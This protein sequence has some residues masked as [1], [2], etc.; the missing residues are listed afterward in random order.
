[1]MQDEVS[2]SGSLALSLSYF[3]AILQHNYQ[4]VSRGKTELEPSPNP[5]VNFRFSFLCVC[6]C[7]L[8]QCGA[9]LHL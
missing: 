7:V 6:V 1:M 9:M 4:A 2:V 3:R 5:I 8:P